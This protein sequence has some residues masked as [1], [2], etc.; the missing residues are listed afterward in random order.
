M[1]KQWFLRCKNG[2]SIEIFEY[3]APGQN[4]VQ[5]KNSDVGG[6]HLAFYVDDFEAALAFLKSKNVRILVEP[7]VRTTGPV[8]GQTWIYFLAPWGMQLELIRYPDGKG[9][10]KQTS[11]RLWHPAY[12]GKY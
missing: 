6:H 7:T 8:A 12:L 9:F 5:P 10:E 1:T 4:I 11:R 3:D 2:A